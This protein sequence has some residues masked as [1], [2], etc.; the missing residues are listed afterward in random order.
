MNLS[1]P[2]LELFLK[3]CKR[4]QN[5]VHNLSKIDGFRNPLLKIDGFRG[6]HGTHANAATV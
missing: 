3:K 6:T 5:H 1:L 4:E 2:K